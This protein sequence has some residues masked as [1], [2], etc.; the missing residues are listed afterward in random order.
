MRSRWLPLVLA[1]GLLAGCGAISDLVSSTDQKPEIDL[2]LSPLSGIPN[3]YNKPILVVK[4]DNIS[5][6]RPHAGISA[7]E[8]G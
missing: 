7:A 5:Q 6:A 8:L 3:G 1:L 4:I 2:K